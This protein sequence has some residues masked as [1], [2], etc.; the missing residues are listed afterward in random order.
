M[1]I[2]GVA[3]SSITPDIRAYNP[4][5]GNE[6]PFAKEEARS[7]YWSIFKAAQGMQDANNR[8]SYLEQLQQSRQQIADLT[9]QSLAAQLMG[10]R[11]SAISA[12]LPHALLTNQFNRLLT[13]ETEPMSGAATDYQ[14][15]RTTNERDKALGEL[16]SGLGR[17]GEAQSAPDINSLQAVT[18]MLFHP[19]TPGRVMSA[20]IGAGGKNQTKSTTEYDV[21]NAAGLPGKQ[22]I[23]QVWPHG[24]SPEE[25]TRRSGLSPYTPQGLPTGGA[26]NG[27]GGGSDTSAVDGGQS[28]NTPPQGSWQNIG[29]IPHWVITDGSG[30][31]MVR[32]PQNMLPSGQ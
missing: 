31:T 6:S 21:K 19:Q 26:V 24:T 27:G 15:G 5:V 2:P 25:I 9:K 12:A 13:G 8:N 28:D 11:I 20:G 23:T 7:P 32:I 30:K 29:G 18:G 1:T 22:S 14:L 4:Q 16:F 17:N 3:I 10:H